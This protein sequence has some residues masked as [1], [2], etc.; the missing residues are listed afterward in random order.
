MKYKLAD[1][2]RLFRLLSKKRVLV[3]RNDSLSK[4][5]DRDIIDRG[6]L[7]VV[8][9]LSNY[10][11]LCNLIQSNSLLKKLYCKVIY[12]SAHLYFFYDFSLIIL[13]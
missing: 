10:L 5:I 6:M 8:I 2:T 1:K 12:F 3:W 13:K 11:H 9:L 4:N 7:H